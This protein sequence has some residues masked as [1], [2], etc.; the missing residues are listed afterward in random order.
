MHLPLVLLDLVF[1]SALAGVVLQV[2][3]YT[4]RGQWLMQFQRFSGLRRRRQRPL[5]FKA[6]GEIVRITRTVDSPSL[7]IYATN[8][9]RCHLES[10]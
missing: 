2:L 5:L 9:G 10:R 4:D 1:Q 8:R 6:S 3:T 7:S